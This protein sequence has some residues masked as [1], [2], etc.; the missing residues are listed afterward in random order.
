MAEQRKHVDEMTP[1]EQMGY[2]RDLVSGKIDASKFI[3]KSMTE[4]AD[5]SELT[6]ILTK[7]SDA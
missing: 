4:S 6:V 2:W 3:V 1:N 5:R 7:P